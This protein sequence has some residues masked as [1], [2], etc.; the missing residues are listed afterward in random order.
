MAE[1]ATSTAASGS[2]SKLADDIGA[3]SGLEVYPASIFRASEATYFLARKGFDKYICAIGSE[4][5]D[6]CTGGEYEERPIIL[7][8]LHNA[9]AEVIREEFPWTA[10]KCLARAQTFGMGDRLG[11]ATPGHIRAI[12][13]YGEGI[14]PIL[15]QQSIREMNATERSPDD[16]INAATWGV[17]QE[18]FRSGFGSNAIGLAEERDIYTAIGVGFTMFT[19]DPCEK[20]DYSAEKL[21]PA[22]LVSALRDLD[23]E[24]L[25]TTA[26]EMQSRYID[27]SVT[28]GNDTVV[29]MNKS[30]F[31]RTA[32]KMGKALAHTISL[33]RLLERIAKGDYEVE[34]SLDAMRAPTTIEEHF[35]FTAELKRLKIP[36]VS[37]CPRMPGSV[38]PAIEYTGDV[39]ALVAGFDDHF[40]VAGKNGPYK[41]GLCAGSDKFGLYP[42]LAEIAEKGLHVKTSGTS[43]LEAMR[44][45]AFTDPDLFR[46]IVEFARRAYPVASEG[47]RVSANL[48]AIPDAESVPE[49]QLPRLLSEPNLRQLLSVTYGEVLTADRC[50]R[51]RD[52]FYLELNR[53]EDAHYSLLCKH[54]GRHL[55]SLQT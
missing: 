4:R 14:K 23:L 36:I 42:R 20:I 1:E 10:P 28:L 39:E 15:A 32:A 9:N 37:F 17:F 25:E 35:F 50:R 33:Y 13:K 7:G 44:V 2:G 24:L 52:R 11:M 31:L 26:E 51:F 49:D 48:D 3:S 34:V 18:G 55:A 30:V 6:G 12:L 8:P 45:V 5:L 22:D 43:Y 40:G 27:K 54:L 19:I 47:L 21:S 16:V 41:I 53:V 46:E 38:E 29:E